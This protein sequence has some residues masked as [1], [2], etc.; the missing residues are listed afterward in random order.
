MTDDAGMGATESIFAIA[1]ASDFALEAAIFER[2][3]KP[4]QGKSHF[5]QISWREEVGRF[6]IASQHLMVSCIVFTETPLLV[7][8]AAQTGDETMAAMALK[9]LEA[10]SAADDADDDDDEQQRLPLVRCGLAAQLLQE[11]EL[12]DA[13]AVESLEQWTQRIFTSLFMREDDDGLVAAPTIEACKWALGV[14]AT[15][16]HAA[17]NPTRGCLGLLA[18]LMEHSCE[19]NTEVEIATTT[20]G[21][22]L[23]LRTLRDVQAGEPLTIC[24][25][26]YNLPRDE[27]RRRLLFQ[28][29]FWCECQRCSGGDDSADEEEG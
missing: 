6:L 4:Q 19:P 28:Y 10:K 17:R 5:W 26:Q 14:A 23:T 13:E 25:V 29:G 21:S 27:R 12:A 15:N 2:L 9:L 11:A 20:E 18:S 1:R 7:A 22:A 3:Q 16:L 8:P 24:Y